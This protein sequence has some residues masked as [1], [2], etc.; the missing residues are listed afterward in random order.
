MTETVMLVCGFPV[1]DRFGHGTVAD[2][3][4]FHPQ[5]GLT[6]LRCSV[7]AAKHYCA[8]GGCYPAPP[9]LRNADR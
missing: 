1:W 2:A 7:E 6:L 3:P 5:S 4:F 8:R 9:D